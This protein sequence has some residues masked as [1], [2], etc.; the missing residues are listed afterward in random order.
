[1]AT[2]VALSRGHQQGFI[3]RQQGKGLD[4]SLYPDAPTL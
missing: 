1:M 3:K 4:E 2:V